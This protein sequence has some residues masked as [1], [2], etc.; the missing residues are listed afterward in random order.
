MLTAGV[1]NSNLWAALVVHQKDKKWYDTNSVPNTLRDV[2]R[3]YTMLKVINTSCT[4]ISSDE[5]ECLKNATL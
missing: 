1:V 2:Y 3:W 4:T 5:I